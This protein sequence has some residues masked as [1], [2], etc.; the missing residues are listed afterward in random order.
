MLDIR[1]LNSLDLTVSGWKNPEQA[2]M[3]KK[4]IWDIIKVRNRLSCNDVFSADDDESLSMLLERLNSFM[5]DGI[6]VYDCSL[7][8]M[9]Q[10]FPNMPASSLQLI[11]DLLGCDVVNLDFSLNTEPS[12]LKNEI[13]TLFDDEMMESGEFEDNFLDTEDYIDAALA[14]HKVSLGLYDEALSHTVVNDYVQAIIERFEATGITPY[15][16]LQNIEIFNEMFFMTENHYSEISVISSKNIFLFNKYKHLLPKEEVKK[17][18]EWIYVVDNLIIT[19]NELFTINVLDSNEAGL[20]FI[21]ISMPLYHYSENIVQ[22][23]D[24]LLGWKESFELLDAELDRLL[25]GIREQMLP[26][27]FFIIFISDLRCF[28]IVCGLL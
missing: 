20:H 13:M 11:Y 4:K 22:E 28:V 3:F 12:L 9:N 24:Y 19:N 23:R 6:T 16:V 14:L 27:P 18:E 10:V 17:V 1:S 2:S 5:F 21:I 7:D 8:S 15:V 26:N 25:E